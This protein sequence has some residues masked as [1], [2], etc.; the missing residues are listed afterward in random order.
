MPLT[1]RRTFRVRHYECDAYG[2]VN[3][4]NYLR[5]MQEAAFDASAEAGY[6]FA[7]Y[8]Q[9]RRLWL[10]RETEIEYL[11]PLHYGDSVQVTTWVEDFRRV[12][13]RRAYELHH[14][15]SG[16]LVARG[17]TDWAFLD[18][19]TGRPASIPAEMIRAFLPEG[20]STPLPPRERFPDSP[21]PPPGAF[22]QS[23]RVEWRDLDPAQHVN[24]AT[25]LSYI[26]DCGIQASTAHGW[27]AQRMS[28]EGFLMV[29][30]H[31]RIAYRQPALLGEQ[32]ELRTWLSDTSRSSIV[33]HCTIKRSPDQAYVLQART[34]LVCL[35]PE[36]ARPIPIPAAFLADL[37]PNV[38]GARTHG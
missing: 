26:E 23:R 7:R 13:S 6:S 32:L 18:M 3:Q 14:A 27:P 31:H 37:S 35:D 17:R 24:N 28:R 8:E 30:R 25:Y 33:R 11:A 22:H 5:Y 4:A 29:A 21:Q 34:V 36:S 38:A 9:M 1:H 19:D 20:L 12:R 16:R 2:H 15:A 10:V